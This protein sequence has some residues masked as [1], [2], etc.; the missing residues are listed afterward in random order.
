[1]E[2]NYMEMDK[3]DI[4]MYFLPM[5]DE[6]YQSFMYLGLTTF[7]YKKM[8]FKEID[9]LKI[10]NNDRTNYSLKLRNKIEKN[11]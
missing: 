10:K 5:I 11:V 2:V 7:E 6:I 4:Y 8:V 3:Q 9:N 1:M